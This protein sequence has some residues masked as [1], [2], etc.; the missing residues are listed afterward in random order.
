MD[1]NPFIEIFRFAHKHFKLLAVVFFSI[2]LLTYFGLR[3]FVTPKYLSE[4]VI[5]PANINSVSSEDP[6][7]QVIQILAST[8]IKAKMIDS[9]NLIEHYGFN[10]EKVNYENLSKKYDRHIK[11]ERTPYSSISITVLDKEN[12]KAANMANAVVELLDRKILKMRRKKFK[13]WSTFS[14]NKYEEKLAVIN[15]IELELNKIKTENNIINLAEQS[16][17]VAVK[18]NK[19][20]SLKT[21]AEAKLKIYGQYNTSSY[22]DSVRKYTIVLESATNKATTLNTQFESFLRVGDKIGGL[23]QSLAL[24]RETLAEYKAEYEEA[25]Q[26]A[27]RKITYSF[28]VSTAG[29]ADK[30]FTP[31]KV[32]TSGI[33]ALSTTL[34]LVLLLILGE[35]Y[36]KLK[37]QL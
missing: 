1:S 22:R 13:E 8:D 33:T 36:K 32:I 3:I 14:K 4:A 9:F 37:A 25:F 21:E 29:A 17:L 6:T 10:T 26:N 19:A 15:N 11:A 16:A 7:E 18:L 31:K 35:Q 34:F 27:K 5:Y 23:E 2:L 20:T 24:E 30:P 12:T 28:K